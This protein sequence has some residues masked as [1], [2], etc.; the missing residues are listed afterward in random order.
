MSGAETMQGAPIL[1]TGGAGFIGSCFVR[2]AIERGQ[3]IVT[4][5]LLT[6]AGREANFGPARNSPLH[7]F[8]RL[9][10]RD[11]DRVRQLIGE[12]R[13][14]AI[15]HFA[16]E[17]HVDRSINDPTAFVTTNVGGTAVLLTAALEYWDK[18]PREQRE[19]FRML[20]VSTDEVFG[21]LGPTGRFD[22]STPYAPRSPYAAS[23]AGADHLVRAFH[24]TY[25]LPTLIGNCSNNYGP[26][27]FP[28]KLIPL[29][30]LRAIRGETL[31][32][33]GKGENVRDWMH[34][35]DHC[36]ALET[37]LDRAKPGETF[38]IGGAG[39]RTNL[40][41]VEMI[42]ADLDR[43]RPR[44]DGKPYRAQITFVTD[45]PGHDFRY[46][47]D[48]RKART[49]LGWNGPRPLEQGIA[50][51]VRWYLDNPNWWEPILAEIYGTERLGLRRTP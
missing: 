18:L 4:L 20:H 47:I 50:A 39:E 26:Y 44:A 49:V 12:C 5:D 1:V 31:P 22:E 27:Q 14:R 42:C 24:E 51:T 10:I 3:S 8:V 11:R 38:C 32:V 36:M 15:V 43:A 35:E 7:R 23:K 9:D 45:R 34:V 16:A 40:A 41:L 33:Y 21:A 6:Y 48:S 2:R 13:P 28:E 17:T 37:M 46:A 19:R 30:I 25:G 29:T